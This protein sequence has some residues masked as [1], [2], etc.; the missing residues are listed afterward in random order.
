MSLWD[1]ADP[2]RPRLISTIHGRTGRL[3]FSPDGRTLAV[4]VGLGSEF[5]LWTIADRSAPAFLSIV[6]DPVHGRLTTMA[7]GR[8][9]RTLATVG[10]PD[11]NALWDIGDPIHPRRTAPLLPDPSVPPSTLGPPR[12]LQAVAFSPG[13]DLVAV[14]ERDGTVLLW[15][16]TDPARPR[17]ATRIADQTS[18]IRSVDFSPDGRMLV[19]GSYDRT[20]MVWDLTDVT[21]PQRLTAVSAYDDDFGQTVFGPDAGT[22]VTVNV[23]NALKARPAAT[24]RDV[25]GLRDAVS[26]PRGLAC[27]LAGELAPTVWARLVPAVPFRHTCSGLS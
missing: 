19:A 5:E 2:A 20:L 25:S 9:G 14:G 3:V 10:D 15:D 4:N 17:L 26:D 11:M 6:A 24:V 21:A 23:V 18:E 22:L 1:A 27:D 13:R 7:F 16:A 8:D 12:L